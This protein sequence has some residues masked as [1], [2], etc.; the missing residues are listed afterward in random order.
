[1][2]TMLLPICCVCHSRYD[3]VKNELVCDKLGVIYPILGEGVPDLYPQD[4]RIM[5]EEEKH[6]N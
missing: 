3:A 1:M 5:S 6:D 2:L 4:G